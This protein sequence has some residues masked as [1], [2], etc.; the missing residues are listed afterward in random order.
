M[1]FMEWF[2][3][4][5]R[6]TAWAYGALFI[7]K[8][9]LMWERAWIAAR[10]VHKHSERRHSVMYYYVAFLVMIPISAFFSVIPALWHERG[11]FF[12]AYTTRRV[13]RELRGVM[14]YD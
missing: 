10:V 12:A 8:T 13:V 7:A 1:D 11:Q 3:L 6:Y 4:A 9:I 5:F 14:R 2:W